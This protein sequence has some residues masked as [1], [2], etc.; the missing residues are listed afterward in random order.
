[1]KYKFVYDES[2]ADKNFFQLTSE[3]AILVA[4]AVSG[5]HNVILHGSEPERLVKAIKSLSMETKQTETVD[6][7]VSSESLF[8]DYS[9]FEPG[10]VTLA[11]NGV[12]FINDLEGMSWVNKTLLKVV[13]HNK[14][15][16]L[17]SR[18]KSK[19]L[20]ANFQLVATINPNLIVRWPD[21]ISYYRDLFSQCGIV[22]KCSNTVSRMKYSRSELMTVVKNI[23][24][25]RSRK[26]T[27]CTADCDVR[28]KDQVVFTTGT[29]DF[30]KREVLDNEQLKDSA[31][32]IAGVAKTLR[33][34]SGNIMTK[35]KNVEYAIKYH[36]VA[37]I[38]Q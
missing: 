28:D 5:G 10:A 9:T 35:F 13:L 37:D 30:F 15:V 8:G 12:L 23:N 2:F 18:G 7:D 14:I 34:Y 26:D 19:E 36:S 11:N 32:K 31:W 4:V 16:R 24:Y 6:K 33:F 25:A 1:M 38:L 20:P 21:G 17:S 22:Y 27:F 29:W 3:E